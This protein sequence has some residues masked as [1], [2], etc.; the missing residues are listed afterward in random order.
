MDGILSVWNRIGN[1]HVLLYNKKALRYQAKGFLAIFF[2]LL[3]I[4]D[5]LLISSLLLTN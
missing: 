5:S 4:N 3:R 2:Y 1:F